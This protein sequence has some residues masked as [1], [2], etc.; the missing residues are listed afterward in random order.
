[1]F[2]V[3]SRHQNDITDCVM[4]SCQGRCSGVFIDNKFHTLSSVSI[5]NFEQANASWGKYLWHKGFIK[6][7][8]S[9]HI[10]PR[11]CVMHLIVVIYPCFFAS[12]IFCLCENERKQ[13]S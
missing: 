11:I 12:F 2:K 4:S 1:M 10:F 13:L 9:T 6:S 7:F 5:G 3:N 8:A